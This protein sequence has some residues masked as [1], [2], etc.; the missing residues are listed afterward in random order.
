MGVMYR[1]CGLQLRP[2]FG[3]RPAAGK[4][5]FLR[6][7]VEKMRAIAALPRNIWGHTAEEAAILRLRLTIQIQKLKYII[8]HQIFEVQI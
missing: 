6:L 5:F 4:N 8:K 2:N 1:V 7:M 3:V